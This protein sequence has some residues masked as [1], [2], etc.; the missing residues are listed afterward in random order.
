GVHIMPKKKL[1]PPHELGPVTLQKFRAGNVK[2]YR[3]DKVVL[4]R[5]GKAVLRGTDLLREAKRRAEQATVS[6]PKRGGRGVLVP[7]G[8]ILPAAH[9]VDWNHEG[10]MA[11]GD[12]FIEEVKTR[13]GAT[14]KARPCAVEPVADIAALQALD[15]QTFYH[16]AEAFEEWCDTTK[17]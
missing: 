15:Y 2:K 4:I 13:G 16:D 6:L 14:L 3:A 17:P 5:A 7:G 10:G 9:C 8:Y 11:L 1:P 12:H